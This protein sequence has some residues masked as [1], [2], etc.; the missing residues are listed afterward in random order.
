MISATN[1]KI[2]FL[3]IRKQLVELNWKDCT[4]LVYNTFVLS[5]VTMLIDNFISIV[6]IRCGGDNKTFGLM[7]KLYKQNRTEIA[8]LQYSECSFIVVSQLGMEII[9]LYNLN[10]NTKVR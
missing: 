4:V 1:F 8:D 2:Y 7:D 10:G 9:L 3:L 5:Y 6:S